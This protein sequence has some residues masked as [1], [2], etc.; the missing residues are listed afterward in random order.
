M[1]KSNHEVFRH[2]CLQGLHIA[3][4]FS[5]CLEGSPNVL[6]QAVVDRLARHAVVA[7]RWITPLSVERASSERIRLNAVLPVLCIYCLVVINS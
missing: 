6:F 5:Q 3:T 2:L 4:T 7:F 1:K